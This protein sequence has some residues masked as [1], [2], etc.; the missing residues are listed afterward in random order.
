M[1]DF[2]PRAAPFALGRALLSG[3]DHQTP[4][5]LAEFARALAYRPMPPGS[6]Q[7][8]LNSNPL[9]LGFRKQTVE[10]MA[11]RRP[12][13]EGEERSP[14]RALRY[15]EPNSRSSHSMQ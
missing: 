14:T 1:L 8:S 9:T 3:F 4:E 12:E 10:K 11:I 7:E 13:H 6:N 15:S 5:I 2:T